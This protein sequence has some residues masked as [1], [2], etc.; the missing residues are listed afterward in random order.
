MKLMSS[1]NE[2][3]SAYIMDYYTIREANRLLNNVNNSLN[4]GTSGGGQTQSMYFAIITN[5]Q[6][7]I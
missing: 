1:I 2:W 6:T 5:T 3:M 4:N 7:K